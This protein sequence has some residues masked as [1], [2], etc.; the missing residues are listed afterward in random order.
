MLLSGRG[1]SDTHVL[2]CQ[3]DGREEGLLKGEFANVQ[4]VRW[5]GGVRMPKDREEVLPLMRFF[6]ERLRSWST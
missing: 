2:A 4:V 3:V 1:K 5:K 6:A